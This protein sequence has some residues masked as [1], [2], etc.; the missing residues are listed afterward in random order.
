MAG[1]EDWRVVMQREQVLLYRLVRALD[2]L[3][4]DVALALFD[5]WSDL[6]SDL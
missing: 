2:M 4:E 5:A 6:A 3:P 1:D